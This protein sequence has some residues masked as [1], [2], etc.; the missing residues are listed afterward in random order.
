MGLTQFLEY[1]RSRVRIA[2]GTS[3]NFLLIASTVLAF[4]FVRTSASKSP[5]GVGLMLGGVAML[6]AVAFASLFIWNTL[7]KSYRR[8]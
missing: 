5:Q 2:R 8:D 6:L 4:G 1:L 7:D 3:L